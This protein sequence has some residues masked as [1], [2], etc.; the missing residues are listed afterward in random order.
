MAKIAKVT[1][2]HSDNMKQSDL[3]AFNKFQDSQ[4][5]AVVA[6]GKFYGL[7]YTDAELDQRY[8][9]TTIDQIK[10]KPGYYGKVKHMVYGPY[11]TEHAAQNHCNEIAYEMAH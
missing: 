7:T 1:I 5:A 8:K 6:Q 4:R 9:H 2:K 3:N 10:A 11:K